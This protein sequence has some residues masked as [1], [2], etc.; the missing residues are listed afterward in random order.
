[1][2]AQD[3]EAIHD[4]AQRE[5]R[6]I[7]AHVDGFY[8]CPHNDADECACRKPQPGLILRAAQDWHVDLG[9]SILIGDDDRDIEAARRAGVRGRRMP[10][11]GDLTQ[12]LAEILGLR[13]EV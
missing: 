12:T 13:A 4:K 6:Q 5:L 8:Y 7:G 9:A 10:T 3:V 1:M 2:T 11:D